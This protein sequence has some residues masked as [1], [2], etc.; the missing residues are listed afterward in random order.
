MK[1]TYTAKKTLVFEL[2]KRGTGFTEIAK[3]LD[4]KPG[5]IFTMLGDTGGIKPQ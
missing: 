2:W 5:T 3:I 1:R 4:S